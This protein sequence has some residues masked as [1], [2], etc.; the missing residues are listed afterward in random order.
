MEIKRQL[1][2]HEPKGR[3]TMMDETIEPTEK[4]K[5]LF[6]HMAF[7]V[8]FIWRPRLGTQKELEVDIGN[9]TTVRVTPTNLLLTSDEKTFFI[10]GPNGGVVGFESAPGEGETG[11]G[12]LIPIEHYNLSAPALS[13]AIEAS[14]LLVDHARG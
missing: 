9:G 13:W 8:G 5:S 2:L 7:M 11:T 12:I 14:Q 10:D 6:Y 1:P 4:Q 3:V